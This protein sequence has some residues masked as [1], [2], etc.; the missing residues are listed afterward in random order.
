MQPRRNWFLA[1]VVALCAATASTA[2]SSYQTELKASLVTINAA[3][4][5]FTAWDLRHQGEIVKQATSL[6]EGKSALESYRKQREPIVAGFE[7]AYKA[8]ADAAI[9][10]SDASVALVIADLLDLEKSVEA[11]GLPWPGAAPKTGGSP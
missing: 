6:D 9:S 5:G 1:L 11:L 3:R 7:I 4:D 10:P 8:L 2:C